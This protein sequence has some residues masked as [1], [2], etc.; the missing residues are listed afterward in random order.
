M[1]QKKSTRRESGS[2]CWKALEI[3]DV[4]AMLTEAELGASQQAKDAFIADINRWISNLQDIR[5]FRRGATPGARIRGYDKIARAAHRLLLAIKECPDDANNTLAWEF[6]RLTR[7][8]ARPASFA[9]LRAKHPAED[10]IMLFFGA[11]LGVGLT[12]STAAM[13]VSTAITNVALLRILA[14]NA[15]NTT[16]AVRARLN[17]NAKPRKVDD[18]RLGLVSIAANLFERQFKIRATTTDDGKWIR[19]LAALLSHIEC[20]PVTVENAK[21]IWIKARKWEKTE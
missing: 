19:F 11:A 4:E 8:P 20:K 5:N 3:E 2:P 1:K 18:T 15:E 6:D 9:E 10:P 17:P 13:V 16:R 12:S 21:S 14:R 7:Q